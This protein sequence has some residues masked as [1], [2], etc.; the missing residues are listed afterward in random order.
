[1]NSAIKKLFDVFEKESEQLFLVGGFCRDF[2]LGV[3]SN[4]I[5]FATSARPERTM[6]ILKRAGLPAH[7]TGIE[8][9]T[10]LTEVDGEKVE[11][12]TF[13]ADT[14]D[15]DSRKPKVVFGDSIEHDLARRDFTINAMAIDKD[16]KIIDPFNG[17][18]DLEECILDTPSSPLVS[19][20]DDPLRLLR[21]ARFIAKLELTAAGRLQFGAIAE[22][23]KIKKISGERIFEEMSKLLM[24]PDPKPGLDFLVGTGVMKFVF[25]ELQALVDFKQNQGE[26]HSKLVW[27]H[28]VQVVQQCPQK[29]EVRWAGLFH[30]CAKPETYTETETGVHFYQ[31]E[32]LGAN[33]WR[34]TAKRLKVS[35]KFRNHVN[36]LIFNH[37]QPG[38]ITFAGNVSNRALRRLAQKMETKEK[39]DDLFSLSV[40]DITSHN[41][42]KVVVRKEEVLN[43]KERLDKILE[44]DNIPKLALPKGTGLVVMETLGLKPGAE[45]GRIMQALKQKLID[46]DLSVDSDFAQAAKETAK[47]LK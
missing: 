44:E 36:D 22:A 27:P 41:P 23:K 7:P 45:L 33:I 25:P 10:I 46:G 38:L 47:E 39:L 15:K 11:I 18:R 29:P 17:Q 31:H 12:T 9:G 32:V 8:F 30:D 3:E 16:G 1:M 37:M 5:D 21:A 40:A 2:L 4:D 43:L 35:N 20:S 6:A 28:T 24:V 13:R 19:F 26:W 14:Y 42:A 34:D